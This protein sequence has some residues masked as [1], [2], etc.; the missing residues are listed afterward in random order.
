MYFRQCMRAGGPP[1]LALQLHRHTRRRP[2]KP[3]RAPP[4]GRER[5]RGNTNDDFIAPSADYGARSV[6]GRLAQ[7]MVFGGSNTWARLAIW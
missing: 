2:L 5:R 6:H 4:T 3:D 7:E 1:G